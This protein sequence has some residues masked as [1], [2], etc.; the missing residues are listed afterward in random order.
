MRNWTGAG[1]YSAVHGF[2]SVEFS[3]RGLEA[4]HSL[5]QRQRRVW[6]IPSLR[7]RKYN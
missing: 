2:W 3:N 1:M 6:P 7:L 4:S 5:M